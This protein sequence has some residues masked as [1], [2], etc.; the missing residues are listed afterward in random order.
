MSTRSRS[1]PGSSPAVISTT[2]TRAAERGVDAAELE[3]DVAAADDQQRLRDVGQIERAGRVHHARIVDASAPGIAPAAIRSRGSR[4][5]TCSVSFAAGRQLRR[6]ACAR[7]GSPPCPG[8]SAPCAASPADRCRSVSRV[9]DVVL[10]RAQLDRD[11]SSARRTRRP[12][13]SACARLV[14]QLRRRA[15]APSTECSRDRRRR[16]RGSL[17]DRPARPAARDPRRERRRVA[18]GTAADD[19]ELSGSDMN[20]S[21]ECSAAGAV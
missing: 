3:P 14:D 11:R 7:R 15:A 4:A 2:V 19:D 5:R 9:D 12:T 13:P 18:A 10:E 17:R 6:R 8:C 20:V 21:L 1:A 16:R